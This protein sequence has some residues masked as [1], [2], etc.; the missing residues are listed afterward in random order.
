MSL[1]DQ[2]ERGVPAPSCQT[3]LRPII[4]SVLGVFQ[5]QSEWPTFGRISIRQKLGQW[6]T[7]RS[8]GPHLQTG[9]QLYVNSQYGRDA[10]DIKAIILLAPDIFSVL[11][12]RDVRSHP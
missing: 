11:Q 9:H 3:M 6:R 7:V 4:S 10:L 2:I 5:P 12:Y 8:R 1:I